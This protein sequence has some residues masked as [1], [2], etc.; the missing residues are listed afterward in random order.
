[1]TARKL[2]LVACLLLAT[3]AVVRAQEEGTARARGRAAR[4]RPAAGSKQAAEEH[5]LLYQVAEAQR[6]LGEQMQQLKEQLDVLHGEQ[7]TRADEQTALVEEVKGLRE[8]V[9]GL[10]V[11]IS[12]VKQQIDALKEDIAGV[13]S[14]VSSF[15]T[16]SGFFIAVMILLLV[17]TFVLTILR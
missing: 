11:E 3:A 13:D 10:Y 15:R 1:M 16:F 6:G 2:A 7:A 4:A 14:N 17:V 8:E 12:G 5:A 9:K